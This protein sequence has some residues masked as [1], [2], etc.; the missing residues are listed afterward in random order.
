MNCPKCGFPRQPESNEC[1]KCGIL[2][3]KYEDFIKSKRTEGV[4]KVIVEEK[5]E[6]KETVKIF[7]KK[8]SIEKGIESVKV[9]LKKL[10]I[11]KVSQPTSFQKKAL[12]YQAQAIGIPE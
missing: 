3:D 4:R 5:T 9:F 12:I 11:K 7:L 2:F 10:S 1:P 6:K 8:L